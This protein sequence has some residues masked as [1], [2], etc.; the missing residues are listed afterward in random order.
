MVEFNGLHCK[1]RAE[2]NS[3]NHKVKFIE[4]NKP[5]EVKVVFSHSTAWGKLRELRSNLHSP[6]LSFFL[7][8]FAL[9]SA[10]YL[11]PGRSP[12]AFRSPEAEFFPGAEMMRCLWQLLQGCRDILVFLGL[13]FSALKLEHRETVS[14]LKLEHREL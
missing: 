13:L 2:G 8:H 10:S 9:P 14:V 5:P 6:I 4:F 11:P 12:P 7:R 1:I 3:I